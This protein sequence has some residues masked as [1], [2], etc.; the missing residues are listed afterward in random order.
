MTAVT[1]ETAD[2]RQQILAAA[3]QV[4][5]RKGFHQAKIA[6]IAAAAGVGK[7]TV[8]E[9]FPSKKDLFQ[10]QLLHV[11]TAYLAYLEKLSKEELRLE[12]FLQRLLRESLGYLWEHREIARIILSDL[13][14]IDGRTQALF[15]K[16]KGDILQCLSTY[17]EAAI[18]RGEM[19][20]L[21]PRLVA[22]MFTG[23]AAA[24]NHE[25]LLRE[26]QLDLDATVSEAMEFIMHGIAA[27]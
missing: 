23:L 18:Q 11:F 25:L 12:F 15:L 27:R 10:Q 7:G 9:Y 19:R 13:P 14:P 8:Y 17:F 5:A 24:V 26:Q 2:K 3:T 22:T 16:V 21:P 20:Q 6:D 4:F 1:R